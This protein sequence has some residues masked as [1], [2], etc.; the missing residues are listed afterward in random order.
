MINIDEDIKEMHKK[1]AKALMVP[2]EMLTA[3]VGTAERQVLEANN[4]FAQFMEAFH[5]ERRAVVR[6]FTWCWF[7][8]ERYAF[9]RSWDD[10]Q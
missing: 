3:S 4:A 1:V 8:R 2:V 5:E 6:W 9:V 10:C 7:Q